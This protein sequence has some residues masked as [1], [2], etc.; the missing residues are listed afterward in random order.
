[1]ATSSKAR[2]A[3]ALLSLSAVGFTSWQAYEG[4]SPTAH[5]PTKG[6]KPTLG[7]GSTRYEDG[8]PVKLGDRITRTRAA[9]LARNLANHDCQRM[10]ASIPSVL[11]TQ[12]EYDLYCDFTGQY[13]IGNWRA[14]SMRSNLLKGDNVAA[15]H[16]LL[17]YRKAAGYD[18]STMI[19][20]KRND[21]CW[22]VWARQLERHNKCM[23][24][25]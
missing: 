12:A 18:C 16:S 1:M 11:L 7:H 21:R 5:I 23:A 20:G 6:D 8:T 4:F 22:G 24:E 10:A 13:G 15:C 14:S 3:A 25:Q 9:E 2:I 19:N 17:L